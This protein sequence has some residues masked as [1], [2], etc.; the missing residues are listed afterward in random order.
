[1]K[2]K[3]SQLMKHYI[4]DRHFVSLKELE[5]HFNVSMNTVR[6]DINQIIEDA[7]FQKV[8]GG[9]SV[10]K[11]PLVSFQNRNIENKRAKQAIAKEAASLIKPHDLIYI[12]SGTTTKY[13]LDYLPDDVQVSVITNSLD[14]ILTSET[15]KNVSVFL[16][17]HIYRKD[18]RSFVGADVNDLSTRYNVDKAFM[19]ATAVSIQNGIMNSDVIEYDIKKTILNKANSIYLLADKSKFDRSTLLTYADLDILDVIISDKLFNID[20]QNYFQAHQIKSIYANI[21]DNIE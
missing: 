3:R 18:T 21:N 11:N 14:V 7:R 13:I 8:Y 17:G 1:M 12:D 10:K 16:I 6:R 4:L 9:I 19:A 15:K 20:Y 2:E 5:R